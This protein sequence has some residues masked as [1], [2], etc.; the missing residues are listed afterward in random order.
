MTLVRII[1]R[2]ASRAPLR[3]VMTV[4]AVAISL[5]AFVVLR[6]VSADWTQ[7]VE[8]SPNDRVVTRHKLGWR[9]ELPIH[10]VEEIRGM[11]GVTAAM[12]G[13][14]VPLRLPSAPTL[15]FESVAVEAQPFVDIHREFLAPDQQKQAFIADRR[16]ALVSVGLARELGWQVGDHIHL[17]PK[18][19]APTWELVVSG[20]FESTRRGFAERSVYFHWEYFNELVSIDHRDR[21][22]V[23]AARIDD[24]AQGARLA[25]ALDTRFNQREEPTF[26]LED[27]ALNAQLVGRYSAILDALD[28]VSLLILAI[29]GL[30][31]GNTVAMGVRERSREY[32]TLRALGF[33]SAHVMGIVLGEATVLGALGGLLCPILSVPLVELFFSGLLEAKAGL[34]PLHVSAQTATQSVVLGGLVGFAAAAIP[35]YRLMRFDIV[36]ALKSVA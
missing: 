28:A 13:S 25:V 10:Y 35:S 15:K 5:M 34:S 22:N 4:V 24:P 14:F 11:A 30:I 2:N 20:V 6:T 1:L 16:G 18:P 32:G 9:R 3:C 17:Q 29:V 31:L 19:G 8:Q 36:K 27:R 21:V 12:G 23:I 7:R 26:S 33:G